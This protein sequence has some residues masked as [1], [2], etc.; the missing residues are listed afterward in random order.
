MHTANEDENLSPEDWFSRH[1]RALHAWARTRL[2][3]RDVEAELDH[4][5]AEV[6]RRLAQ[7]EEAAVDKAEGRLWR[8]RRGHGRRTRADGGWQLIPPGHIWTALP[9]WPLAARLW[10]AIG[11]AALTAVCAVRLQ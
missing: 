3:V 5:Y 10:V 7:R 8:G 1:V 2:G 11:A 9:R 6:A 4:V